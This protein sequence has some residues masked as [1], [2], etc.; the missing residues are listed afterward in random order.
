LFGFIGRRERKLSGHGSSA[1]HQQAFNIYYFTPS[2][3]G[4][5]LI[6]FVS[7][8]C[9]VWKS[10]WSSS[11]SYPGEICLYIIKEIGNGQGF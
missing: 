3:A 2:P 4:F 1:S 7:Y 11:Y 5:D 8:F 9:F 10:L 6:I